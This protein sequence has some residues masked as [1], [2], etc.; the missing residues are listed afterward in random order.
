[1]KTIDEVIKVEYKT[2][3]ADY[4]NVFEHLLECDKNFLPALSEK[5]DIAM[6]SDKIIKNAVTFEAWHNKLLV[7]FIAAYFNHP[8]KKTGFITN[9]STLNGFFGRGIASTLLAM[10]I[11][12]AKANGFS[13]IMLEVAKENKAAC[14]LYAK[15][16][17]LSV[18]Q[19]DD[20]LTMKIKL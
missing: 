7:G 16:N 10:C 13:E 8:S 9:V 6:Y 3:T 17:F 19:T 11:A 4:S 2:K 18:T 20:L 12:H 14:N 15:H 5:I 1:M